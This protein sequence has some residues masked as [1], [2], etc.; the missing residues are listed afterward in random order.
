M[1]QWGQFSSCT[2]REKEAWDLEATDYLGKNT[3]QDFLEGHNYVRMKSQVPIN[4][5]LLQ[6]RHAC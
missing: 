1:K 6:V 4:L 5:Q 2:A 3:L